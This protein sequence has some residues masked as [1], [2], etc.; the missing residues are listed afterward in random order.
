[1]NDMNEF[2]RRGTAAQKAVNDLGAGPVKVKK[3]EYADMAKALALSV[4][5]VDRLKRRIERFKDGMILLERINPEIR[6]VPII[7]E[8]MEWDT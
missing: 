2:A 1:M 3:Q 5:E 8:A 7:R 4:L 6:K